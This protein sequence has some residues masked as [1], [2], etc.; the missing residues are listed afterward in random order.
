MRGQVHYEVFIKRAGGDWTLDFATEDRAQAIAAAEERL[1][2]KKAASVKVT[3]ETLD[4]ETR[5]FR[6]IVI[7]QKG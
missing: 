7:L 1:A 2:R 3:K 5:E 4:A 6:T